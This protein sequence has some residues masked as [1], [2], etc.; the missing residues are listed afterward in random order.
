MKSFPRI[1]SLV[2]AF[3]LFIGIFAPTASAAG[4]EIKAGVGFVTATSLRM[5]SG[6]GTQ[7]DTLDYAHQNEVV[8]LLDKVGD[9]YRVI[10]NLREGYMSAKYLQTASR[11]NA[12]LGWGRVN[13]TYVNIRTGPGTGHSSITKAHTGD[14][15]YIIGINNGWYKI[16]FGN[17]IGYIRSDYLDLTEIPY[18]NED[19]TK[20]P[21]FFRGGKSTGVPV[22]PSALNGTSA[23]AQKIIATA[24]QYLGVPYLWGGASPSGFDCSGFVQ[25]VFGIH[26]ITLP[27]T[28]QQQWT[29][30]TSVSK[31]SLIPGDLVFFADTYAAGISH[32]G[33]YIGDGQ[34]IH[35][36]SSKGV[37]ISSLNSSYWASHYYGAK[38][39][40]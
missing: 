29:V 27:R 23:T 4:G 12:E 6:P 10:Y 28:S 33:I 15:A 3:F 11:E 22:S 37:V 40:L 35:S 21:L 30:G 18:E 7:Y 24:R 5:R 2:L 39:V 17:N 32:L 26:G 1:V 8:I 38:R 9:W 20:E 25:Y 34:F 19:S 13:D 16:I 31:G 14:R 36:S